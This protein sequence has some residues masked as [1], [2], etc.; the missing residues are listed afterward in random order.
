[1]RGAAPPR[2]PNAGDPA[3][4]GA[5]HRPPAPSSQLAEVLDLCRGPTDERRLVGLLLATKLLPAL[6][7]ASGGGGG[8]SERGGGADAPAAQTPPL[9]AV[10]DAVGLQF[11]ERLLLPLSQPAGGDVEVGCGGEDRE[12]RARPGG[13]KNSTCSSSPPLSPSPTRTAPSRTRAAAPWPS[14]SCPPLSAC[15]TWRPT[16]PSS[17][18]RRP[19][20]RCVPFFYSS[21]PPPP[22]P[23][24]AKSRAVCPWGFVF[25]WGRGGRGVRG[26]RAGCVCAC[27]WLCGVCACCVL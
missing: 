2:P 27:V 26:S 21:I 24:Q 23:Q 11:M 19:W 16:L 3:A 18:W 13:R 17:A 22:Q 20:S 6:A 5:G 9:R 25:C 1:M 12:A 4:A 14:P 10:C 7:A 8:G 15:P